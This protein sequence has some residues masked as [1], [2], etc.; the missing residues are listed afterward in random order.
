MS[1]RN[2]L[3]SVWAS[4]APRERV[5]VGAAAALVAAA[6]LWWLALAP[7]L[8]TLR[9]APVQRRALEAQARQMQL[10]QAQAQALQAQPRLNRADALKSLEAS[11]SQRLGTKARLV[12]SGDTATLTL[13]GVPAEAL[14]AWLA[15][16]RADART[17]P[18]EAHLQ[19]NAAGQWDGSLVL[20][21]PR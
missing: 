17:L 18:A 14:S 16:A 7:A 12:A 5:L 1:Q 13:S 19:R 10:L 2:A 20:N 9:E 4:M 15:Q 6:L 3:Q 11:V 8:A 21:L